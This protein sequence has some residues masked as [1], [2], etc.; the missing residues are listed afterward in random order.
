MKT[1]RYRKLTVTYVVIF[2]LQTA[3]LW[4]APEH[5]QELLHSDGE[6]DAKSQKG[7][8]YSFAVIVHEILYRSGPYSIEVDKTETAEGFEISS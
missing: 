5:I 2:H 8:V 7:D 1:L 4:T 6:K 3:M